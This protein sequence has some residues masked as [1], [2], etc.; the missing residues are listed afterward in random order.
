MAHLTRATLALLVGTFAVGG[1]S[2]GANRLPITDSPFQQ[3]S[4]TSF[5]FPAPAPGAPLPKPAGAGGLL[6]DTS[7]RLWI[8]TDQ[9]VFRLDRGT[10]AWRPM[11]PGTNAG[12]A[13]ALVQGPGNAVYAGAWNGLHR[14]VGDRFELLPAPQVPIGALTRP[15]V[16]GAFI[17]A[18]PDG[19]WRLSPQGIATPMGTNTPGTIRHAVAG[20]GDRYWLATPYG[21][22]LGEGERVRNLHSL[23]GGPSSDIRG[24]ALGPD[25]T[26]WTAG[27][28]GVLAY[29]NSRLI[30]EITPDQGLPDSL[31]QCIACGSGEVWVGTPH[32]LGRLAPGATRWTWRHSRRWLLDDDVRSIALDTAGSVA[33]VATPGGVDR[34]ERNP[35]TLEEKERRFLEVCLARHIREPGIVEKCRLKT[36]GD[37]STWEPQDDDN[38][39]GYTAVYL[40]ME[41]FRYAVT[42]DPSAR[43]RA[44][45]AFAACRF[46]QEVTGTPGFIARTVVPSTW[47]RMADP[48]ELLSPEQRAARRV[49]DARF[50]YVP[51]R[52]KKSADGRWLWKGDTS[53]DEICAHF[54]GYFF[55]DLLAADA[56]EKERIREQVRRIMDHILEHDAALVDL[57][58][59]PTRWGVW[60]PGHLLHNPNWIQEAW[61]NPVELSSFLKLAHH[62]TG[63]PRYARRYEE[64]LADVE[65]R[66]NIRRAK[67]L[68]PATRTHIDDELLA[69]VYAP[70]LLLE[71][72]PSRVRLY[73]ESLRNW[74]AAVAPDCTPFFEVLNAVL[75][76][77]QGS[78]AAAVDVLRETPL[79][80]VR[81]EVD[82]THRA[83]IRLVRSPELEHWHTDRLLPASERGVPRT[84]D[85]LRLAVQGEGGRTES[86]GVFW[87][88]PYWMARHYRLLAPSATPSR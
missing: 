63:D 24:M 26:L 45:R 58:G 72:D 39:G 61:I 9:G 84:D 14:W 49:E 43:D 88:L 87:M 46:L 22:W 23:S 19:L 32:G 18:G 36:P 12:P 52:W 69:F 31:A 8:A 35:L 28:G 33:Y 25:G 57:D 78:L 71:K 21:L 16:R 15:D 4:R 77:D 3:E 47:T 7:H 27:L 74:H 81:W 6:L 44:R 48:N 76:G 62:L 10:R 30:R 75:S 56:P 20:T 17:A 65:W 60:T 82:N 5:P 79:D 34:L 86:D 64:L 68:N 67:N 85:N 59:K 13:F 42:G 80:L 38:D 73:R 41:S 1:A 51:E 2:R 55:Y 54:F 66:E 70:L 50:K 11:S 40:A 83:D 53:S 29:R 37:L